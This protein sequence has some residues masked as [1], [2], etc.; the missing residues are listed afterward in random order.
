MGTE[1]TQQLD[2]GH[3]VLRLVALIIDSIILYVVAWIILS[4]LLVPLLFSGALFWL[5]FG[6][7]LILPLIAGILEVLYFVFFEVSMGA[8]LGKKI[9]GLQ[10]QM[11]N[12]AKVTF[13]KAIIRNISKIFPLFLLLDWIIAVVTPTAGTDQRQKYS[14]RIA[15]TTV[16]QASQPFASTSSTS[17]QSE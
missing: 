17:E 6:N 5:G 2:F 4:F 15:G 12:G 3:W 11:L 8:T 13:D 10:V 16:V 7:W 9:L 14:D 1:T